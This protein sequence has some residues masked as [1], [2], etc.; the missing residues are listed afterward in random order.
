MKHAIGVLL[1][2]IEGKLSRLELV[3][4]AVDDDSADLL[5]HEDEDGDEEGGDEAG[6]VH[7][8]RV[9]PEGHDQ[10][11]A[12]RTC[13]LQHAHTHVRGTHACEDHT[14]THTH[15]CAHAR[16]HAHTYSHTHTQIDT[17]THT[18]THTHTH[19]DPHTDPHKYTHRHTHN[20]TRYIQHVN[21]KH[22]MLAHNLTC[23]NLRKHPHINKEANPTT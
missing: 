18:H 15:A 13:G 4:L 22:I 20:V 12:V 16:T 3:L 2:T 21:T 9:L 19:T 11:A 1:R 14:H 5:V 7:P 10:P 23:T 17:N 8:P 6:H